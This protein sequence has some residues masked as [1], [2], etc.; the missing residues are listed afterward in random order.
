MPF[1]GKQGKKTMAISSTIISSRQNPQVHFIHKL[2]AKKYRKKEQLF[3]V[4]GIREIQ[5]ALRHQYELRTLLYTPAITDIDAIFPALPVTPYLVTDELMTYLC[6]RENHHHSIAVFQ[7]KWQALTTLTITLHAYWIAL[8]A[9]KKPDNVGAII[10][11]AEAS[12][13]AGVIL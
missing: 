7:Q 11:T 9:P 4:E 13:A 6:H 12:G 10:R 8:E 3:V 2:S 1:M 5:Q